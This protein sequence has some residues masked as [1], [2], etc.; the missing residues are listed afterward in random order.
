MTE[1]SLKHVWGGVGLKYF[2]D[3]VNNYSVYEEKSAWV[4]CVS[5]GIAFHKWD[6]SLPPLDMWNTARK[7]PPDSSGHWD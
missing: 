1:E 7:Q 4:Q 2:C 3:M 5:V 6:E